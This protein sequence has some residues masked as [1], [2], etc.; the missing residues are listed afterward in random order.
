MRFRLRT[1]LL[2]VA[3]ILGVALLLIAAVIVGLSVMHSS[4][5]VDVYCTDYYVI[6]THPEFQE[7]WQ[8][9]LNSEGF[10]ACQAP[11]ISNSGYRPSGNVVEE[12]WYK[13]EDSTSRTATYIVAHDYGSNMNV[14][15]VVALRVFE[16]GER[17]AEG[18]ELARDV[19][20]SLGDWLR[21]FS[22]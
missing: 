10:V 18:H 3:V 9:W 14:L 11:N 1:L 5:T 12:L 20:N 2:I 22:R 4:R 19:Y 8:D 21:S 13:S 15:C 6:G 16:R 17:S 7:A